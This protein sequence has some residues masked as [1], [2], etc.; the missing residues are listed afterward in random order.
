[1][2]VAIMTGFAIFSAACG[3]AACGGSDGTTAQN[4]PS[5]GG[6]AG[7]ASGGAPTGGTAGSEWPADA[8]AGGAAGVAGNPGSGGEAGEPAIEI[9]ASAGNG[10]NGGSGGSAGEENG[11]SGGA[12]AGGTGFGGKGGTGGGGGVGGFGIKDGGFVQPGNGGSGGTTSDGGWVL[13]LFSASVSSVDLE[14]ICPGGDGQLVGSFLAHYYSLYASPTTATI[15]GAEV[16]LTKAGKVPATY[17]FDPTP[18]TSGALSANQSK[19]V[20]HSVPVS[21]PGVSNQPICNYCNG[22]GTLV[23][24]WVLSNGEKRTD[25]FGPF[26]LICNTVN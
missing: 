17:S 25:S 12:G 7:S 18:K 15:T 11:G 9:D 23:V 4:A 20:K 5:A 1:M 2:R 16:N 10:G 24:D 14:A 13:S 26:T 6:S 21:N 19:N 22:K 3:L 8:S